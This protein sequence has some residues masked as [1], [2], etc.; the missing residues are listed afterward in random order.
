MFARVGDVDDVRSVVSRGIELE[1]KDRDSNTALILAV[2]RGEVEMVRLLLDRGANPNM[3]GNSEQTALLAA[4]RASIPVGPQ[5]DIIRSLLDGGA[6]IDA[7]DDSGR[8][9]L[10][11]AVLEDRILLLDLLLRKGASLNLRYLKRD[12]AL[13]M[14]DGHGY[15]RHPEALRLLRQAHSRPVIPLKS[16]LIRAVRRRNS[17]LVDALLREGASA[18]TRVELGLPLLHLAVAAGDLATVRVLL[19]RGADVNL[20]DPQGVTPLMRAAS[21]RRA[22][23][24]LVHLLL[25]L[26]A[27]SLAK[28]NRGDDAVIYAKRAARLDHARALTVAVEDND[29]A[30]P[31]QK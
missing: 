11:G 31:E 26:G 18:D 6:D 28:D 12:T 8:T 22:D 1:W 21:A 16:R 13:D 25:A 14:A 4:T 19:R 3:R 10:M 9:A 2:E 29:A 24:Q 17:R 15:G 7:Q 20:R 5:L 27:N 23:I 30:A